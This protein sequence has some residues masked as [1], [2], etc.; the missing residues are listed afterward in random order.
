MCIIYLSS[1]SEHLDELSFRASSEENV[2]ESIKEFSIVVASAFVCSA[3]V[4]S[5]FTTLASL[6][7][8]FCSNNPH[9]SV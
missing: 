7:C 6:S 9:N 1:I 2:G 5:S 4:S 3:F 8:P